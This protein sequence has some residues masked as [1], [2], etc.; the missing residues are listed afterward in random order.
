MVRDLPREPLEITTRTV[1]KKFMSAWIGRDLEGAVAL[2]ADDAVF[3]ATTGVEPGRSYRGIEAIRTVF[4]SLLSPASTVSL[5]TGQVYIDGDAAIVSWTTVDSA[6]PQSKVTI[7]G[8]DILQLRDG[9]IVPK[10]SYRT[11]C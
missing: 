4:A 6:S 8:V 1:I 5:R 11:A 2:M 9:R 3:I 10:D 7:K